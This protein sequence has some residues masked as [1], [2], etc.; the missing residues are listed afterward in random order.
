MAHLRGHDRG[1]DARRAPAAAAPRAGALGQRRRGLSRPARGD[2]PRPRRRPRR[3]RG[4]GG[5]AGRDLAAPHCGR[6]AGRAG[7]RRGRGQVGPSRRGAGRGGAGAKG[8]R[9]AAARAGVVMLP[10]GSAGLYLALGSPGV[11]SEP[12]ASRSVAAPAPTS[13]EAMVAQVE[14]HLARNP[15]D[16][17]GWEVLAPIYLRTGRFDDAVKARRNALR[18]L[19]PT[20][21]READL[22][23]AMVAAADGVVT[24]EARA[25][26]DRA[27]ALDPGDVM[28]RYFFGLAAEQEGKRAEAAA[29]WRKLLA[30]APPGAR[31]TG[32][33]QAALAQIGEAVAPG[34]VPQPQAA[35][36]AGPPKPL[37]EPPGEM[38]LAMVARLAERLKADG[39][40]LDGWV[41]L[42]R[43][44]LVLGDQAKAQAALEDG[45]RALASDPDKL[46][47]LDEAAS[48]LGVKS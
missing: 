6:G 5:G 40:D 26:F 20:A 21:V 24:A 7:P 23:Q 22:G 9:R 25:A 15:E 32:T 47:R 12:L 39:S 13:I 4:S 30:A 19:G 31:W 14:A 45:R 8:G 35:A 10:L 44:Y 17:R 43:S 38:I 16:G 48:E 34:A 18:L 42:V 3:R 41:R 11:P 33:V 29:I 1:G 46:R 2:R 27:A 36:P 28:A 37:A